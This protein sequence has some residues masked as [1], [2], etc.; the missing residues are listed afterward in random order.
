MKK[1]TALILALCV[2]LTCTAALADAA[3]GRLNQKI[4]TRTGPGTSYTEP[5]TFLTKGDYVTVHT[6]VWDSRNEIWWVQVEFVSNGARYRAYTGSWRM[7]VDL[8]DVPQERSL[9][10]VR[11][12]ADA[13]VFAG[14]GWDYVM[15]ND[16]V[17]RGTTAMLLEV[18]GGYGHIECWNSAKGK[19]WRVWAPLS[20]LSC[21]GQYSSSEDTYPLYGSPVYSGGNPTYGNSSSSSSG[22]SYSGAWPTGNTCVITANTG[23]ARS[24]AG[25]QYSEVGLVAWG[26]CYTI[27]DT[28]VASNGVTWY[29]INLGGRYGWISSGLTNFGKH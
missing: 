21:Y 20:C 15:W 28:D 1:L 22:G 10:T 14:P 16:T 12:T 8:S 19:T 2:M 29:K 23:N 11:V 5:G 27:L 24:G 25:V 26:D 9:G 18:E 13:D 7:N 17:Y 3:Y 4:A 6:K